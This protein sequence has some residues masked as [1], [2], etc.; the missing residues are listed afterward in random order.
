MRR[1][2]LPALFVAVLLFLPTGSANAQSLKQL[3]DK[4]PIVQIFYHPNG[5]F[6]SAVGTAYIKGSPEQVWKVATD[7]ESY[8]QF[9]P[10]LE[11]LKVTKREGNIVEVEQKISVPGPDPKYSLRFKLDEANKTIDVQYLGGDIKG[12]KWSYKITPFE[13][14][15]LLVYDCY[16]VLPGFFS[17]VE[18]PEQ[19]VTIGVNAASALAVVRATK[20]RVE[21]K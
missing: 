18:G 17:K 13:G 20:E 5:K 19:T 3:L 15:S 6:K 7:F 11:Y 10:Q 16:S 14:G 2:F 12:G 21:G 8:T 9:M 4:G 1:S